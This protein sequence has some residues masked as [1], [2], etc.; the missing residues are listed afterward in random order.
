M[1]ETPIEQKIWILVDARVQEVMG[2]CLKVCQGEHTDWERWSLHTMSKKN[3]LG[4]LPAFVHCKASN[5]HHVKPTH[6][7]LFQFSE[8]SLANMVT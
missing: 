2:D 8:A 4:L 7:N 3:S 5:C 6:L 1:K